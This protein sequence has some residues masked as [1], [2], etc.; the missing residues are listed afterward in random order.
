MALLHISDGSELSI[1]SATSQ[2][3]LELTSLVYNTDNNLSTKVK[4]FLK[5]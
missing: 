3:E 1:G 4:L 2:T 5:S